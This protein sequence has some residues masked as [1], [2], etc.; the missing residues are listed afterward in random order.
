MS[1]WDDSIGITT[2]CRGFSTGCPLLKVRSV[3]LSSFSSPISEIL[4]IVHA[5]TGRR[6]TIVSTEMGFFFLSHVESKTNQEDF[7]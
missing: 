3:V 2:G 1:F 4:S 6:V 7:L 5:L